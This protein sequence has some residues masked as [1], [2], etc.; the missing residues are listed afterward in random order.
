MFPG[1]E[2]RRTIGQIVRLIGL[3]IE[4]VGLLAQVLRTRTDQ[5]GI[6]LP[7]HFSSHQVWIVVGVGFAFWTV[8]T[9]LIYLPQFGSAKEGTSGDQVGRLRL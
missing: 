7:G 3:A 2:M 1:C 9:I 8:G 5:A 6:P 4:V